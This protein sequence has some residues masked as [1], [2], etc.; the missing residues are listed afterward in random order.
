M[1]IF[2]PTVTIIISVTLFCFCVIC[3][4]IKL[5]YKFYTVLV[6]IHNIYKTHTDEME[7]KHMFIYIL[8]IYMW[9]PLFF[10]YHWN[11]ERI[12][13]FF[14][15]VIVFL[16]I[17]FHISYSYIFIIQKINSLEFYFYNIYYIFQWII[18]FP[19]IH[20]LV[21]RVFMYYCTEKFIIY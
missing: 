3:I 9:N 7:N 6:Y 2:V 19:Y 15:Y 17:F 20:S 16:S 11:D 10:I 8:K 21:F 4:N 13:F 14:R 1:Y 12:F 18:F 5:L